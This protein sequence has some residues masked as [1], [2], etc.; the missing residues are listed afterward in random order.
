MSW[1]DAVG[2]YPFWIGVIIVAE[3]LFPFLVLDAVLIATRFRSS[4]HG[5]AA[6]TVPLLRLVIGCAVFLYV[7]VRVFFDTATVRDTEVRVAIAN[8]PAELRGL[9]LTLVADLQVDRYTGSSKITQM[10]SIVKA[11]APDLLLSG[12]DVVTNGVSF[13]AEAGQAMCAMAG[14]LGSVAVMGDHDFWSA[15]STIRNLHERCGWLFLENEHHLFTRGGRRILV[16]GLTHIYSRKLSTAELDAFL[17]HA[18]EADVRILLAHQPAEEVVR[19]ASAHRYDLVV[20]GH[21]HGGQIVLHPL[22]IP[23]TPSMFETDYYQGEYRLGAT[24]VIV[25]R[26]LGLTLAPIRYHA[27]AEVVTVELRV[28]S[29]E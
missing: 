3:L 20:A 1:L 18:P 21:T 12:G 8:L 22:G 29:E 17:S 7:P 28:K 14:T 5:T 2:L 24:Q 16:S 4:W 27:P 13:L 26:G 9:R 11:R 10:Q 19:R 25:S 6:R 23:L 15:P